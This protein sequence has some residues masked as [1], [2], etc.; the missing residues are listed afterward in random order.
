MAMLL[1]GPPSTIGDL[2][3]R[4]SDLL[5]VSA[6]EGIDLSAKLQL[7]AADFEVRKKR[8]F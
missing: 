1:D 2:S 4:D 8:R 6:T 3:I 5:E 7:A